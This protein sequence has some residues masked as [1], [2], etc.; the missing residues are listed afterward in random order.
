MILPAIVTN[1][2]ILSFRSICFICGIYLETEFI[3]KLIIRLF[4]EKNSMKNST[5]I[6]RIRKIFSMDFVVAIFT[7]RKKIKLYS[8]VSKISLRDNDD[9]AANESVDRRYPRL[10]VETA[11]FRQ[12]YQSEF[13]RE[14]RIIEARNV[15]TVAPLSSGRF[16]FVVGTDNGR[17]A[18]W[19]RD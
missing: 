13:F 10:R 16:D 2:L 17:L 11:A 9:P 19:P 7:V 6:R 18:G 15:Y 1:A 4:E 12:S 3:P 14:R 5:K 8:P